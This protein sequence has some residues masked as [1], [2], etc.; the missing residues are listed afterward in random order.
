M[1]ALFAYFRYNNKTYRVSEVDFELTPRSNFET[2]E[3]PVSYLE[4][5]AKVLITHLCGT[6]FNTYTLL[7]YNS[8]K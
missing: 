7:K 5:F 1:N 6:G 8:L 2:R 4:Y 3:G